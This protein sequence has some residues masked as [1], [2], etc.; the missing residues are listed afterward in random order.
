MPRTKRDKIK[1]RH[2]RATKAIEK[3]LGY[4]DELEGIFRPVHP[5]YAEGYKAICQM[6]TMAHASIVKIKSYV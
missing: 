6:L 1:D 2:D 4:V 5:E 3:A